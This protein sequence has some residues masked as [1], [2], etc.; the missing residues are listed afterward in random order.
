MKIINPITIPISTS[1][2]LKNVLEQ[3]NNYKYIYLENDITLTSGITINESKDNITIN[4][5]YQG[6][7]YTY[8]AINSDQQADTIVASKTNKKITLKNINIINPNPYGVISTP[9][10]STYN[11]VIVEYNNVR[12][13]GTQLSFVPYGTTRVIDSTITIEK[14]TSIPPKKY[15][16]QTS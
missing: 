16:R 11:N 1:D 5:T 3:E 7:T 10:E 2:E 8:T 9:L 13:N 15:A 4:C 14:Q 6:K 12:F